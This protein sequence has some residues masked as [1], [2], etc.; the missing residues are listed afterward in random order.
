ML[1]SNKPRLTAHKNPYR[2]CPKNM[3][4]P[5]TSKEKEVAMRDLPESPFL[6][7]HPLFLR[8]MSERHFV[9]QNQTR[10]QRIARR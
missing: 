3:F 10:L 1:N 9:T 6:S 8:A 5:L 7:V 4:A 2:A